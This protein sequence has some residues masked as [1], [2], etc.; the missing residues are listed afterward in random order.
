MTESTT[1]DEQEE[2][3][4][5]EDL[6][7]EAKASK[8]T[9]TGTPDTS[10][11][12]T[13]ADTTDEELPAKYRDK[14]PAELIR[15]HQEAESAL[16]RQGSEVGELRSTI[17]QYIR[18][19]TVDKTDQ[20]ESAP[21]DFDD[22]PEAAVKQAVA[23]DPEI[24]ALK[25]KLVDKDREEGLEKLKGTHDVQAILTDPKFAEWVGKS[26]VRSKLFAAADRAYDWE[27][28]DELFTG[29]TERQEM[30]QKL[31]DATQADR[32]GEIDKANT[33]GSEG[34][35]SSTRSQKKFRRVDLI[36]LQVDD[37]KRYEALLPDIRQAYADKRVV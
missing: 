16:G 4:S 28:A 24:K 35:A 22:D 12:E 18:S 14:T 37:P 8:E 11:V 29:W 25:K 23:D 13:K 1:T 19:Q 6:E 31:L 3:G 32:Q 33:G 7:S 36:R 5:I 26:K 2:F 9:E 20:T 10:D 34:S 27:A 17:D 15:M 30:Q 21:L